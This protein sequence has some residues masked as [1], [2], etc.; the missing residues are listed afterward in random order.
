MKEDFKVFITDEAQKKLKEDFSGK[1]LKVYPK[2]KTWAGIIYKI[3]QAEQQEDDIVVYDKDFRII[4]SA[5]DIELSYIEIDYVNDWS[6]E[7][8]TV[9]AGF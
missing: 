4:M 6:G 3:A 1:T 5:A 8:Y 7:E 2:T 9:T